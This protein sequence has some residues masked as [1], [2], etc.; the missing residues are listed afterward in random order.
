VLVD[1]GHRD[2]PIRADHVGKNLPTSSTERVQVRLTEHDGVDDEVTIAGGERF[3]PT[4]A[5]GERSID[6]SQVGRD[7]VNEQ[8]RQRIGRIA[9]LLRGT[10]GLDNAEVARALYA[11][12]SNARRKMV[13]RDR[14]VLEIAQVARERGRELD[15]A[16]VYKA[17]H[18]SSVDRV[19][20][21]KRRA[22]AGLPLND[23]DGE[24]R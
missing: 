11:D 9:E 4:A 24:T 18:P 16:E 10:P 15:V 19:Q 20:E 7:Q 2:L 17:L 1:R 13:G 12:D 14:A 6:D 3:E 5:P 23:V 21:L 8:I 22:R